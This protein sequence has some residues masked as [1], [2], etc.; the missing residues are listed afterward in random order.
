MTMQD[1]ISDM[2]T[3]I[4]NA[5]AVNKAEVA[6]PFAKQKAAVAAVL[7]KE[8]YVTDFRE[9][10]EGTQKVLIIVL[11]YFNGEPVIANLERV[12]KPSLR[13]YKGKDELP[14]VQNGL[15][16]AIISTSRGMMSCGDARRMGQGGEIV[17]M[18]N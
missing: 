17:C 18:V 13:V 5:Q 3:R 6:M 11:K 15:G 12:S 16:I 7:K 2:L 8:G 14:K 1:P 9:E 10:G 4:R